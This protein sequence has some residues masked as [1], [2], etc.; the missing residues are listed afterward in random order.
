MFTCP[1]CLDPLV[2]C[3]ECDAKVAC[4]A[5]TCHASH[6]IGCEHCYAHNRMA[7]HSC[8]MKNDTVPPL[9][10]CPTCQVW[11][12]REDSNWCAGLVVQPTLGSKELAELSREYEW[13]SE[14]IVR[15]HPPKPGP[16][17]FCTHHDFA[18][19]WA[20]CCNSQD[21]MQPDRCPSQTP[22]MTEHCLR[23]AYCPDCLDQ[24]PGCRCACELTWLCDI[25]VAVGN[26]SIV[27]PHLI[28]CPRCGV[29]YC[30]SPDQPCGDY[31]ELCRGCKGVILCNDCQEEEELPGDI[32][33][34]QELPREVVLTQRCGYCEAWSCG[35]C[36]ASER[37]AICFHC[38][39]WFCYNCITDPECD[40]LQPCP[41][42]VGPVCRDCRMNNRGCTGATMVSVGISECNCL[43][44]APPAAMDDV[45]SADLINMR[46]S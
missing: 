42:C 13:D 4:S 8:L 28:T 27:Y 19:D 21:Y 38:G 45:A 25:C 2:S 41:F 6:I 23:A 9:I 16:C 11:C 39:H 34:E 12:C 18:P 44:D 7:C 29:S 32:Q 1:L 22:F 26:K 30:T 33:T 14:T 5:L 36:C 3:V 31:I 20:T 35:D 46:R 10:C 43:D 17:R 15:S 24:S 40:M 37:T